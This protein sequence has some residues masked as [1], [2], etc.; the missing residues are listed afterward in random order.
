MNYRDKAWLWEKYWGEELSLPKI[1]Y[2]AQASQPTILYWMRKLG[3]PRR[4]IS[5]AV[6]GEKNHSFGQRGE[7]CPNWKGGRK[8]CD[9]YIYIW[10]PEHPGANARG[11]I[12]E[13]RLV[14]E[15]HLGRLLEPREEIHH[16]N[17]VK[18]DN[19]IENLVLFESWQAH[20]AFHKEEAS[21]CP[22]R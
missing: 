16:K 6:R 20:M 19:R 9:G 15:G 2:L 8:H 13:H 4:T 11:H 7:K 21:Q 12:M 5:E 10:K 14:M 22:K 17:G 3:I 1:A 18:D